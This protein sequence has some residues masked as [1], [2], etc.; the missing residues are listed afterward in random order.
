MAQFVHLGGRPRREF[1]G[2]MIRLTFMI[3]LEKFMMKIELED[4]NLMIF[5]NEIFLKNSEI[6]WEELLEKLKSKILIKAEKK[7]KIHWKI[8]LKNSLKTFS[9]KTFKKI[10][11]SKAELEIIS[12]I[13]R[14]SSTTNSIENFATKNIFNVS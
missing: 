12:K 5:F 3:N 1:G 4:W 8:L 9:K 13:F 2:S 10:E 6:F 11:L 7:M 14:T